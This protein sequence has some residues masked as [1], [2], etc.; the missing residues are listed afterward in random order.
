MANLE[1]SKGERAD[2]VSRSR[3]GKGLRYQA[4]QVRS[5]LLGGATGDFF[6]Q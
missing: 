4:Q 5:D 1:G 6:L 2:S 3:R